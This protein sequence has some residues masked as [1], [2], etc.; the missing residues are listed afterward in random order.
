M[1]EIALTKLQNNVPCG[2]FLKQFNELEE[3]SE[4]H[5]SSGTGILY[6]CPKA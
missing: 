1:K 2:D 5:S 3:N 4:Y 6:D